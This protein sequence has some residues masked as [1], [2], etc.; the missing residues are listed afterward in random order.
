MAQ[1]AEDTPD[2]SPAGMGHDE[3][4]FSSQM[5]PDHPQRCPSANCTQKIPYRICIV[6]RPTGIV[7]NQAV[8][9]T[10]DSTYSPG[11]G[12][13]F[14]FGFDFLE[15]KW[16]P[17]ATGYPAR[18]AFRTALANRDNRVQNIWLADLLDTNGDSFAD[19]LGNYRQLTTFQSNVAGYTWHPDG[20]SLYVTGMGSNVLRV[21]VN[22]GAVEEV[23][24]FA[25]PDSVLEAPRYITIFDRPG[26]NML[27]AFQATYESRNRLYVYD[28]D[29]EVVVHVS[30]FA[31]PNSMQ[32]YPRW[33]PGKMWLTYV[34]NYSVNAWS[35]GF[36]P[37]PPS[38]AE[39]EYQSR[40][41]YP[42][43]WVLKL[44][45]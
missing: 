32:L 6:R 39:M 13:S 11:G 35:N 16:D 44:E 31:F 2:V 28:M 18:I 27:M 7:E 3:I 22:S 4:L 43:A 24:S 40:T 21:N 15:P 25:D 12:L 17:T 41:L 1:A 36:D 8:I 14:W 20:Q 10:Q 34:S 45:D 33:H 5:D 29:V 9:L 26:E 30:P 37:P 19:Q 42:S 23:L 38:G